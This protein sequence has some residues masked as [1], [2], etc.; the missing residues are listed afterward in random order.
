MAKMRRRSCP[1][2]SI[3]TRRRGAAAPG[4]TR[5]RAR[6]AG[7]RR[8]RAS[9]RPAGTGCR[10][11]SPGARGFGPRWAALATCHARSSSCTPTCVRYRSIAPVAGEYGCVYRLIRCLRAWQ[12]PMPLSSRYATELRAIQSACL[13][14]HTSNGHSVSVARLLVVRANRPCRPS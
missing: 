5:D 9:C 12:L 10:A 7:R 13:Y 1:P 6:T 3:P 14:P 4:M 2:A 11:A 8:C